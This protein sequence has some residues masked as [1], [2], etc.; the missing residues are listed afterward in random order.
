MD[1]F[2]F[3]AS[4]KRREA[5]QAKRRETLQKQLKEKSSETMEAEMRTSN[6]LAASQARKRELETRAE[7]ERLQ[8]EGA[9]DDGVKV[10]R[11]LSP[12]L[13]TTLRADS[14]RVRLPQDILVEL[15]SNP[16][17][18]YPLMFELYNPL[19]KRRTHCG[20]LDFAAEPEAIDIPLK[21]AHCLG[22]NNTLPFPSLRLRYKVLPRCTAVSLKVPVSMYAMFPDFRS[23]LESCLRSQYATLTRGDELM[24]G[25]SVPLLVAETEPASA[26]CIV[27]ADVNLDLSVVGED[28]EEKWLV[29]FESVVNGQKRLWLPKPLRPG[30]LLRVTRVDSGDVMVSFPPSIEA[31]FNSFDFIADS[32]MIVSYEEL[33]RRQSP[34]FMTVGVGSGHSSSLRSEIIIAT[35]SVS[36]STDRC[37]ICLREVPQ[38]SMDL[39]RLRCE[40]LFKHCDVCKKPVPL[41][42]PHF[43]CSDCG[44]S[45]SDRAAHDEQWHVAMTCLCGA[46]VT[47]ATV[48]TH[49]EQYCP[50]KLLQCRFCLLWV[51]R[52]STESMD[53]R[54]RIMGFQSE[55][56]AACGNRTD[57]CLIC[58]RRERLK[59]MEF[60]HQAF[61]SFV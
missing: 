20:V 33:L 26:V 41:K 45:Y 32:E 1:G 59:D 57:V 43:H 6:I 31:D 18:A 4:L 50:M 25:G 37:G 14:D 28:K 52:G 17:V 3:D 5:E 40:A 24:I 11:S 49:R 7:F 38:S 30:E 47:R 16:A 35:P 56:E 9:A 10:E 36:S 13:E 53:A 15:T 60:H 58:H 27:D 42:E 12:R 55:H 61:H 19:N 39:H 2:G 44:K 34:E 29:G 21:I 51:P 54:D 8:D 46:E 48:Q 23:F 22:L